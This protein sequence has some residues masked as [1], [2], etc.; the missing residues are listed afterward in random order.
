MFPFFECEISGAVDIPNRL[1]HKGLWGRRKHAPGAW[2]L[3]QAG[4]QG[5]ELLL[6]GNHDSRSEL[7]SVLLPDLRLNGCGNQSII[8]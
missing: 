5:N 4:A 8:N 3:V 7:R 1:G 2:Q 6:V